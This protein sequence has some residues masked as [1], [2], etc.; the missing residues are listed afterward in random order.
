MRTGRFPRVL[1]GV[2]ALGVLW[3]AGCGKSDPSADMA[4]SPRERGIVD[5]GWELV[6]SVRVDLDVDGRSELVVTT[7]DAAG[8]SAMLPGSA[9]DRIEVFADSAGRWTSRFVDAVDAGV[10]L[11]FEDV[12]RT[13]TVQVLVYSD[14]GGNNPIA[15]RGLSIYGVRDGRYGLWFYAQDGDPA[16]LD[17]DGDDVREVLLSGEYWGMMPHAEAISYT[18]IVYG[19]DGRAWVPANDLHRGWFDGQIAAREKSYRRVLRARPEDV[20]AHAMDVHRAFAEWILWTAAR[21]DLRAV[22]RVW[23][24]EQPLL[25]EVLSEDQLDDLDIIV[26][27]ILEPPAPVEEPSAAPAARSMT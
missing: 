3:L 16:V 27:D 18:E 4:S 17:L 22:Q 11:S 9:F 8:P 26:Q 25:A 12:A 1:R 5:A 6:D 13:G 10:R 23:T 24:R 15:S 19:F 20:D 7:R 2:V 14:G 21:G